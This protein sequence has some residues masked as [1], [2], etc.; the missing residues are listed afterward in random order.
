MSLKA[1]L[2][3]LKK[4]RRTKHHTTQEDTVI[5]HGWWN[6]ARKILPPS[7]DE[8]HS[9]LALTDG[10]Y[11]K[12]LIVGVPKFD[13]PGYSRTIDPALLGSL[14]NT[15]QDRCFI[16]YSFA[17]TP[18]GQAD[19][20]R[21]L[22]DAEFR[23]LQDQLDDKETNAL[24]HIKNKTGFIARDIK[25]DQYDI[26]QQK[27]KQFY[28]SCS[29]TIRADTLDELNVAYSHVTTI[30]SNNLIGYVP[31]EGRML[32]TYT[33]AQPWGN[34][35]EHTIVDC[36]SPQVASLLPLKRLDSR[37]DISG[38]W[39]GNQKMP[40]PEDT[41]KPI[42]VDLGALS[43]GHGFIFGP[44]G[45]GKTFLEAILGMR[46]HDQ[47]DYRV[48]YMTVKSDAGTQFRNVPRFYK[49]RGVVIDLGIGKDKSAIN[50]L[51]II[52]D[53]KMIEGTDEEYLRI[54]HKHK[55][56]VAA[57]FDA[58]LK[59]GLTDNQG[60]YLDMTLNEIYEKHGMISLSSDRIACHPEMWKDGANFPTI[61]E[62][63][64]LWKSAMESGGLGRVRDSAESL[65]NRT[66]N[67]SKTGAYAYINR[68]TNA[69]L[70]K[71]FIVF[72]LSGL[73]KGLQ[74]AMSVLVTAVIGARFN[75]DAKRK[76]LLIIDEGV[77]FARNPERLNFISDAY[78]M[79]RSQQITAVISFTQPTDMTHELAAML[80]TNS[81]W[82]YV[83]GKGMGKDSVEYVKDFFKLTE[84][85]VTELINSE[86]GEGLLI[87]GNQTIPINFKV[88][89]QEMSV[90]KGTDSTDE[91]AST[92]DAF[93]LLTP[94]ADLV[95]E[96][97][98]CLDE[99]IENPDP[100]MMKDRGYE[101]HLVQRVM[102]NGKAKAWIKSDIVDTSVPNKP[103]IYNQTLEH[104]ASVSM[105]AGH[106]LQ[107]G[108]EN[109]QVN[110][111]DDEDVRARLGDREFSFEYERQGSHTEKQLEAKRIKLESTNS[112]CFFVCQKSY[113]KFV[114]HAVGGQNTYTRGTALKTAIDAVL[115]EHNTTKKEDKQDE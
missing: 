75:T 77:A 20:S 74:D 101:P 84:E 99:W 30:L 51:Q 61:H 47:E 113:E 62:L 18:F 69:D 40:N 63:R 71:D 19:S 7:I 112:R 111:F 89:E 107:N 21:A 68:Q 53:E 13:V 67:L 23:N 108:F 73:D 110:H 41:G 70:S 6:T 29:I 49:D 55:M 97:G 38:I 24:G 85:D 65:Y 66:G 11:I 37:T 17:I 15:A 105:I 88:T 10:A 94:V 39:F 45:S 115:G 96:Q 64:K 27:V 43:A 48:I 8:M 83:L 90:L 3:D 9:Y 102:S 31:A 72:D 106:L 92:D 114:A 4:I 35:A 100:N 50:P 93:M 54:Y 28:T 104:Y 33:S 82:A 76:T 109:V 22:E 81:M 32:E 103:K 56:T 91:K 25:D 95:I 26:H 86:I 12:C 58:F 34:I 36:T 57:F 52:Y 44:T 14:L 79:G 78:M 59:T 2:S 5:R 98:F 80:K 16:G 46:A 87:L 1:K 42:M 60:H